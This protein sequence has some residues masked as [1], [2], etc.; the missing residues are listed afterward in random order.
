MR[1]LLLAVLLGAPAAA[2]AA[3][4]FGADYAGTDLLPA[5]GDVLSGTFLNVR[6]FSVAS[7]ATVY[8]DVGS[9]LAVYASTVAIA[10]TLDASGR[11]EPGGSGGPAGASG[12]AGFGGGP[13]STGGGTGGAS[14]AGGGG[15]SYGGAGGTGGTAGAGAGGAVYDSTG[16]YTPPI[17]ADDLFSGSGG[18]GGGGAGGSAGG[19][20]GSGGGAVYLEASSM[21]VTG[22]VL[23]LGATAPAVTSA[24]GLGNPGGGG[25]GSGG[26]LVLRTKGLLTMA[27][28]LFVANGGNGASVVDS[29]CGT[30]APG[31]GG[32]GGRVKVFSNSSALSSVVF[33]T[34][35]GSA[36]GTGGGCGSLGAPAPSAGAPGTVSFGTVASSPT[37]FAAAGATAA[38]IDWTWT[39]T[40]AWGDAPAASRAYRVFPASA[41][42]PLTTPQTT[43]GSAATGVTESGLTP[44][45]TYQRFVT[46]FTDWGDSA[47]SPAVST[48]T[49]ASAPALAGFR[50]PRGRPA[51]PRTP[52]TPSTRWTWP[53]TPRSRR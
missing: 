32:G 40:T 19:S 44:N 25:G 49:L 6:L 29:F 1:A 39:A 37:A 28:A 52:P 21:T 48:H 22:A 45:T 27:R 53:P 46:A 18:G 30:V 38:S 8:V 9:K 16:V 23:L 51:R 4:I 10:G 3:T 14:G 43:A 24:S 12:L 7:G 42:A 31:G 41:T 5:D 20:G 50:R 33:S 17:S 47:V 15:G 26:G 34:A 35:A 36:G 13:S 2:R 11:G